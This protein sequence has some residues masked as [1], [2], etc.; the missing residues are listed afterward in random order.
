MEEMSVVTTTNRYA[1]HIDVL[2][3]LITYL[4]LTEKISRTPYFLA[5]DLGL[6]KLQVSETLAGFPGIFRC[7]RRTG[8]TPDGNQPY[9]TLHARYAL[10][11]LQ[12]EDDQSAEA[13]LAPDLLRTLLDFVSARARSEEE[14]HR[15]ARTQRLTLLTAVLAFVAALAAALISAWPA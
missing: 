3:A 6:P 2:T 15:Q 4:A 10:R 11:T 7:S 14:G 5:R 1:D 8:E 9:F 13:K 12:E